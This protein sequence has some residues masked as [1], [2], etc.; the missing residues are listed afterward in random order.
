MDK[1]TVLAALKAN[2][3]TLKGAR[4]SNTK[5]YTVHVDG[6]TTVVLPPQAISLLAILFEQDKETWT[7]VELHSLISGHTEI[8]EKQEPWKVFAYYRKT[9]VDAG[10]LTIG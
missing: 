9:L 4:L 8:S 6:D 5:E 7:E 10:F 2:R 3:A 1:N